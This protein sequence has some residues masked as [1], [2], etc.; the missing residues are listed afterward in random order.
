M[1]AITD[2]LWGSVDLHVHSGPS[3]FPRRFSHVEAARDAERLGMR[4]ILIKSHHHNTVMDL[5]AMQPQFEGIGT[6]AFGG[7]ALNN[8]VGGINP[9]AVEMSLRMGGKA[10]WLPTFSSAQHIAAHPEGGGFPTASVE[11]SNTEVSVHGA[12]GALLP[13]M[14]RVVDLVAESG[15]LLSGGHLDGPTIEEAFTLAKERGVERMIVAHPNFVIDADYAQA[16]RLVDL[17]AYVEHEVS[18]YDPEGTKKW[19]PKILLDWIE[20]I[21]PEHTTLAS[22]LGQP[23]RPLPVDAFIRVG[24]IL[25][26]LGVSERDLQRMTRDNPGY[27]LGLDD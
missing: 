1:A 17:G 10:V 21:G 12:D 19:D 11:L 20:T 26:D 14:T 2:I 27:L 22:D 24:E 18:M 9:Y 23:N 6:K 25:L 8:Q 15:A 16:Q 5:L 7:I 13:E 3:P 4:A